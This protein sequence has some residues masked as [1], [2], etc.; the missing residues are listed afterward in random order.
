MLEVSSLN[1]SMTRGKHDIPIIEDVSFRIAR[2]KVFGLAGESGCGKSLTARCIIGLQPE[3]MMPGGSILFRARG[4]KQGIDLLAMD[5]EALRR[6]R[7]SEIGMVFQEPMTSLNPV[8]SIGRQIA[9]VFEIHRAVSR[10]E[11]RERAIELLDLVRIPEPHRR[12]NDFPHQFSGGMR[13]RVMIAMAV[14]CSPSLLIADE[15]TTALDVTIQ[16]EIIDLLLRIK[17]H[18]GMSVLFISHDLKLLSEICDRVAIMYAGRI[19]EEADAEEMFRAPLHPYTRGLISSL[20][21]I[22]GK[23]LRPIP[24]SVPSP[25]QY[26]AGCVFSPRCNIR[27]PLCE[28][29][30]PDL[31][32]IE[33]GHLVRCIRV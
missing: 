13:Q 32:I 1:L 33:A 24:G 11:A 15:P 19:V 16:A 28:D 5:R 12:V 18:E 29:R 7:G 21:D 27:V 25:G 6:L 10:R 22:R 3:G 17:E 31:R 20:P 8:L 26:P 30:E 14:A 9:E 23:M 4:E 2:G